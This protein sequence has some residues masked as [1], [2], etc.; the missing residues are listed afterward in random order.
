MSLEESLRRSAVERPLAVR[1]RGDLL[2]TATELA[3]RPAWIVKDPVSGETFYLSLE[4]HRLLAALRQPIS[5]RDLQR[6]VESEFA[7]K[8]ATPEQLQQFLARLYD[9][10]LLV[11]EH[12]DQPAQLRRR[13]EEQLRRRRR[14]RL[15]QVLSVRVASF[16]AGPLVDWLYRKLRPFDKRPVHWLAGL[17]CLAAVVLAIGSAD[18][19]LAGVRR[20][21]ELATFRAL[22]YWIAVIAGVKVCHELGHALVCRRFGAR[23]QEA[24]LLLLAGA[25]AL[26]CDVSD[27]WRLPEKRQRLAVSAAGVGVELLIASLA[28]LVWMAAPPGPLSTIC[29]SVMVVCTAGTLLVNANPLLRYDGYFFASDWFDAPNLAQQARD[30]VAGAMRRWFTGETSPPEAWSSP[31]RRA[32]LWLYA[33]LSR[34]YLAAILCGAFFLFQ[35]LA[36]PHDLEALVYAAAAATIVGLAAAPTMAAA[37]TLRD[38]ARRGK[39]RWQRTLLALAVCGVAAAAIAAIPVSRRV[40]APVMLTL[41]DPHPLFVETPGRLEWTAAAG[42]RVSAGEVVARLSNPELSLKLSEQQGKVRELA[43]RLRQLETLRSMTGSTSPALR[44]AAAELETAERQAEQLAA[45]IEQLVLRSPVEGVVHHPP[46]RTVSG[47]DETSLKP[48]TG[49]PLEP[50]NAGA[51][52]EAGTPVAVVGQ[53]EELKAWS[54]VDPRDVPSVAPGQR[55]ELAFEGVDFVTFDATVRQIAQR[56]RQ[57]SAAE[58]AAKKQ[59]RGTAAEVYHVVELDVAASGKSLTP[60][61]HGSAKILV[62]RSTLGQS[63]VHALRRSWHGAN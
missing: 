52:L 40:E 58:S 60:N 42:S 44:A 24:G 30:Q 41:A 54:A 56:A 63:L 48:W 8:R 39:V 22:P 27:A 35:R 13:G 3:G 23:P 57:N 10:G 9:Q 62:S 50:K 17:I 47:Q 16:P 37:R 25:P 53:P 19:L 12:P 55:V 26:Y 6:I 59:P 46:A 5:L 11:S 31:R 21:G 51:W 20:L 18:Q 32:G 34:I 14:S 15:V 49:S 61:R 29:L 43:L 4:E 28:V 36:R 45:H 7:P 1:A 2:A 33:V 38:P